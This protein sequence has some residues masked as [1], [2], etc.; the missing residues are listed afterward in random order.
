M[1]GLSGIEL[2]ALLKAEGHHMPVILITAHPDEHVRDRAMQ[3][4][5]V[6]FMS[7]PVRAEDLIL[8]LDRALKNT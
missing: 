8:S 6:S 1:P 7:K 3:A 4:G 5:A 2:Q